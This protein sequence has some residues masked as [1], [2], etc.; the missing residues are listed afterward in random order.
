M[1]LSLSIRRMDG[2][3]GDCA[4]VTVGGDIDVYTA[5]ELREQLVELVNDGIFHIVL[6]M[7]DVD[8]LDPTGLGVLF[9][10]LK[11]VH[12]HE[13]SLRLVCNQQHYLKIFRTPR[14]T[15]VFPVHGSV[16]AALRAAL[17]EARWLD[18]E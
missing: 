9:G 14:L 1:D 7:E 5:P 4:V 3:L 12:A 13:G 10:G 17:Y 8:Y 6:D 16:E 18:L 15:K 2:P 11:M